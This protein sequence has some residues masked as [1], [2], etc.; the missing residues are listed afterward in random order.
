MNFDSEQVLHNYL[1]KLH[2][3]SPPD[4]LITP[5]RAGKYYHSQLLISAAPTIYRGSS[6]NE[7]G[8]MS[9]TR[10]SA[11][12]IQEF[13]GE[14]KTRS[15]T[16]QKSLTIAYLLLASVNTGQDRSRSYMIYMIYPL[17][18]YS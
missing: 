8:L 1:E 13:I 16:G 12:M 7:Q 17:L 6:G 9:V 5:H 18:P 14:G 15:G 10:A 2:T 11:A 4:S 3:I